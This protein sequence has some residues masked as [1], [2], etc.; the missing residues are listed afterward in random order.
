MENNFKMFSFCV[1]Q[2]KQSEAFLGIIL[3]LTVIAC[4]M[5]LISFV[6]HGE[7]KVIEIWNDMEMSEWWQ[8]YF[9]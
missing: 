5:L 4:K 7:K 2:K 8:M 1:M 3:H 9:S 6:H